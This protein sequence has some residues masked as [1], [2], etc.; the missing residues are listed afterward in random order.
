M[1]HRGGT[2]N[3]DALRWKQVDEDWECE[4][5]VGQSEPREDQREDVVLKRI[6]EWPTERLK[7]ELTKACRW[8]KNIRM[9][10]WP[11]L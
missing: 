5:Q 7:K 8:K 3:D 6:N 4:P 1:C 10:P 2:K 9:G 11:D